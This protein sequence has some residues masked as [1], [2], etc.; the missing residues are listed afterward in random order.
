MSVDGVRV[1]VKTDDG[2][3]MIVDEATFSLSR[4][5][6]LGIVGESGS[7]KSMLCRALMG[8]IERFGGRV[9]SGS[10]VWKGSDLVGAKESTWRQ[11]R[12]FEMGY[13]PQS[14]LAGLNPLL[15]VGSQLRE[16]IR[17][18]GI[19]DHAAIKARSLELLDMVKIPR[20]EQVLEERSTSLSGGMRQRVIIA[21]ALS[22]QPDLLIL[23]EPTTA[24]DVTVQA[25]ILSLVDSLRHDM[26]MG[27]I[28]VSH[29]L[30]V[31]EMVADKIATMYAGAVVE[32]GNTANVRSGPLHPYTE[33]LLGSRLESAVPGEDLTS[34]PGEPPSVGAWPDG[35][36]FWPRCSF[37]SDVC[38]TG[39]QPELMTKGDHQSACLRVSE[40]WGSDERA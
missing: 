17:L 24:L 29:D 25:E 16:A 18:T 11:I 1:S 15:S 7:G 33:A 8:T 10:I 36:R 3:L 4:G 5:E 34:I 38:K 20:A 21:A 6:A 40:I 12:G 39:T 28:F 26:G 31:I 32:V 19:R 2:E 14:S 30:A 22:L 35:C 9:S 13:V 23:D 37:A 27:I